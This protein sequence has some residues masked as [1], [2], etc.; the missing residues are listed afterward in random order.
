MRTSSIP[1]E[2]LQRPL[3][4]NI[5]RNRHELHRGGQCDARNDLELFAGAFI[6][7]LPDAVCVL[8][9]AGE[10]LQSNLEFQRLFLRPV[11]GG[12]P[13][14]VESHLAESDRTRFRMVFDAVL[15]CE[16]TTVQSLGA[17]SLLTR[18]N[19]EILAEVS[20]GGFL[21]SSIVVLTARKRKSK[22]LESDTPSD[23][24]SKS[25]VRRY[26]DAMKVSEDVMGG[27]WGRA[28]KRCLNL[29]DATR[30]LLHKLERHRTSD[31]RDDDTSTDRPTNLSFGSG[32]SMEA[33]PAVTEFLVK[34][35]E[36][37]RDEAVKK[38]LALLST[39]E[40]K[41]I[42]V[43]SVGHEVRTPLNVLMNGIQVL[44]SS[45]SASDAAV[46][47]I[48]DEMRLA[49]SIA[50]G[51]LNDLLTYEKIDARNF[52]VD[53]RETDAEGI[54]A[55]S[56]AL[57]SSVARRSNIAMTFVD[58]TKRVPGCAVVNADK[59]KM[60]Q[61]M[62]NLLSNAM[63]FTPSGGE[64]NIAT[65]LVQQGGEDRFRITVKDS[66]PGIPKLSQ[67][68]LFG[69]FVQF[70]AAELQGGGGSGLGLWISKEIVRPIS[71]S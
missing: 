2:R 17:V 8:N 21:S 22:N 45:L 15:A 20:L 40:I 6:D 65:A 4:G 64:V 38:S 14:P 54:V 68:R 61:V 56:V 66:G 25:T 12:V 58:G 62:R 67:S 59:S 36:S 69:Q 24:F 16:T 29:Q 28:L 31:I 33:V 34:H 30:Q 37:E 26:S 5:S 3:Q 63:K 18:E 53:L 32:V 71:V 7:Y 49:C 50:V 39:L 27:L 46:Q 23:D 1:P 44:Q 19:T 55:D 42:F 35:I 47:D 13:P 52:A 9:R 48:V 43:R 60:G 51:V 41:R 11:V 57:F 70:N 10:V